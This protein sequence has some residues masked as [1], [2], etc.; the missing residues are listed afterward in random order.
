MQG[1]FVANV[2]NVR[3]CRDKSELATRSHDQHIKE[4]FVSHEDKTLEYVYTAEA[5]RELSQTQRVGISW[6]GK[7][8][9]LQVLLEDLLPLLRDDGKN[10]MKI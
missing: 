9:D 5:W 1:S 10:E 4:G 2:S 6:L 3:T 7:L 8:Q